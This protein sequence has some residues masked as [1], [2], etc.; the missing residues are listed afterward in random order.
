VR[1]GATT[2]WQVPVRW[3]RRTSASLVA[4]VGWRPLAIGGLLVVLLGG[5]V[6][7]AQPSDDQRE[8]IAGPGTAST[9]TATSEFVPA[10]DP[11]TSADGQ[12][13]TT[14]PPTTA[15]PTTRASTAPAPPT[16]NPARPAVVARPIPSAPPP[17]AAGAPPPPW[18]ASVHT[19][20]AG[21]VTTQVGCAG[22]TGAGALDAFFR[23]RLGPVVGLDYQHVYPLG[24]NRYLWL[25]QDT[26]VDQPGVANRLEKAS[27]VHN[28]AM[29]Q[30]GSCFTLYQRGTAK[31]PKSFE[32]GTGEQ[33]LA[34]WFWPMGGEVADGRLQVFWAE[35]V[36]DGHDPG[37]G[38]GLGWH[39]ARTWLATYDAKTL[40]RLDFRPATNPGVT[41]IYGYAVSSDA[42]YSYL[43]GNTFEQNLER[44]GGFGRGPHS[45]TKM[46]LARVP[47]GQLGA[48]PEYRTASGW[49]PDSRAA[50]PIAQRYWVENP[51]QP[52]YIDGQWVSA[53]KVDGYWGEELSIDVA[54]DPWGPWTTVARGRVSPRGGDPAMNTYQAH[55]LPW[56]DR[57]G[58]LIVTVSQNARNMLRDAFPHPERYRL[59]VMLAPWVAA[60]PPPPPTVP[61][62]R[63]APTTAATTRPAPPPTTPPTTPRTSPPTTAPATAPTTSTT[64]TT[65]FPPTTPPTTAPAPPP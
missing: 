21:Y 59:A 12:P 17:P 26:F 52:R 55:V 60:P 14:P 18:A 57:S 42:A 36:K 7:A 45:G 39:P 11:T 30:N 2:L 28:S 63:P 51:M 8:V 61:T 47:R 13:T 9:V 23:Q 15:P 35:M 1:R 49:S 33:V 50:V 27:F 5:A 53:T 37:P 40:A 19:T 29:V 58:A 24:G 44:E 25:F 56:R 3:V 64:T 20:S 16:T 54:R 32:A 62:T 34:H 46:W 48:A 38:D 10:D 6:V 65:T 4:A 43:F 31:R 41:P 22:G